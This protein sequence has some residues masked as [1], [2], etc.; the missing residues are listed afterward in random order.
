MMHPEVIDDFHEKSRL[1]VYGV[2]GSL[3]N[4]VRAM[5]VMRSATGR[6]GSGDTIRCTVGFINDDNVNLCGLLSIMFTL[7]ISP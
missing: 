3:Y 7:W 5:L 1:V 6:L 4:D 2:I